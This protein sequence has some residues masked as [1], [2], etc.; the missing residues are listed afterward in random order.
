MTHHAEVPSLRRLVNSDVAT[1]ADVLR[2]R[3]HQ[4]PDKILLQAQGR[5]WTAQDCLDNGR[6]F[7][8]Y[9]HACGLAKPGVRVA[10]FVSKCPEG[11]WA[12]FGASL[13]GGTY[14]AL[15]RPHRGALLADQLSR[16]RP[17]VL[18]TESDALDQLPD[19]AGLGIKEILLVD[20][21]PPAFKSAG[22]GI[23]LFADALMASPFDGMKGSPFDIGSIVF[24]SGTTERSKAAV[25]PQNQI[26]R[27]AARMV[28]G[29]GLTE[30]DVFHDAAPLSHL[31]GQ[32]HMTMA[33]LIA[34]AKLVHFPGFSASRF[35]QQVDDVQATYIVGYASMAHILLAQ[36]PRPGERDNSLRLALIAGIGQEDRQ[37]FENRFGVRLVDTYGMTEAEPITI[38]PATGHHPVGTVGRL[39]P[40]FDIMI[41]DEKD[42]PVIAGEIGRILIRPRRPGVMMMGYEGD[43]EATVNAWRNLWFHTQDLGAMDKDGYLFFHDRLKHV[44]RRRGENI[45][46]IEME[47]LLLGH[48][49][50]ADCVV[51][52]IPSPLGEQDVKAVIV[53][54]DGSDLNPAG[55]HTYCASI[56]ARYM[57]PRY[58]EIRPMLPYAEHG[59]VKREDLAGINDQTWDAEKELLKEGS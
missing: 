12:W 47:R 51:V 48:P 7:A 58:I 52:G 4:T 31:G 2:A 32:M 22:H 45:S 14:I 50:V 15:N 17:D 3:A 36:P 13:V 54:R 33:A 9:L 6:R 21:I 1:L 41:A 44:I 30:S 16:A 53:L 18:V 25:I 19:L 27:G 11:L 49:D 42:M 46:S 37:R 26:C 43:A 10:T 8:G 59:K 56:M 55:L 23:A 24:T 29:F 38:L 40:D 5:T 34:G 28:D 35:W 57:V 39:T 20:N